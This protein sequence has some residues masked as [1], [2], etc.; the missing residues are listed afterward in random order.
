MKVAIIPARG[1]STRIPRK[2][3]RPFF[4]RPIIAYSIDTAKASGLFDRIYVST[5]DPEIALL[6]RKLGADLIHRPANLAELNGAPDCGT[7]EVARHAITVLQGLGDKVDYACCIYPT[8][9][10]MTELDLR[11]GLD[12]LMR[13]PWDFCYAVGPDGKDAGQFYWGTAQAFLNREPLG[14]STSAR[15]RVP[16]HRYCDINTEVEWCEAERKYAAMHG[17]RLTNIAYIPV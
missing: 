4:G 5:E 10:L 8:A 3:I 14:G 13:G 12:A 9:P 6:A 16:E 11:R 17:L 2:N 1:G 15:H 7:Q